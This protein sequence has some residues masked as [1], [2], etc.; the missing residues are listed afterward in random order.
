MVV[1]V[2]VVEEEVVPV[3]TVVMVE[4]GTS[5]SIF[6]NVHVCPLWLNSN[7][8]RKITRGFNIRAAELKEET[9]LV[10]II[11]RRFWARDSIAT[12]R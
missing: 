3:L 12:S 4:I 11:A 2:V 1:V 6:A 10:S 7:S 9:V 8:P 5:Q